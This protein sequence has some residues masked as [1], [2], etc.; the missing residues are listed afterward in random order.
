MPREN[1][2]VVYGAFIPHIIGL[3]VILPHADLRLYD[4]TFL[5]LKLFYVVLHLTLLST[6]TGSNENKT[7]NIYCRGYVIHPFSN[8][9]L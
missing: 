8:K 3:S 4:F 5:R 6:V 7:H 9:N 1:P 2:M